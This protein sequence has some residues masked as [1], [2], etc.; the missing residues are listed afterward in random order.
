MTIQR[1]PRHG[2]AASLVLAA[3]WLAGGC[4]QTTVQGVRQAETDLGD[5]ES[6]VILSRKHKTQ[7]E[8]EDDF[9]ACVSDQVNSGKDA[10]P[11]LTEREFVDATFPW[12]EPR[13]APLNMDDLTQVINR[14]IISERIDEIGVRYLV[15]IEGQT[16]RSDE[17]GSLQCTV[18]TGG[19]PG[20]LGFLSWE[21]GSNYEASV[22]DVQ[23]RMTVGT[24]SSEAAGTSFV[25][26]VVVP[27]PVIARVQEEACANLSQEI[28]TFL[29]PQDST[30]A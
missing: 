18:V 1:L 12:F 15:W 3:A 29:G 25:I 19:I 13:T 8:T 22:W 9:V 23:R 28:K 6:V 20:C 11:I 17:T 10:L 5:S 30:G 27:V 26:A 7:G 21:R 4:V 2:I 16:Q 14:P 24:L